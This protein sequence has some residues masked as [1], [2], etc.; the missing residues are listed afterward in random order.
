MVGVVWVWWGFGGAG[1]L[2]LVVSWCSG[3]WVQVWYVGV[4]CQ[5]VRGVGF[6]AV[7]SE[8]WPCLPFRGEKRTHNPWRFQGV[9]QLDS[10]RVGVK[11]GHTT[12]G[13]SRQAVWVFA[14]E[15]VGVKR[16][17]T[18]PTQPLP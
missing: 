3:V 2:G 10:K 15:R 12:P 1:C 14:S 18:T 8:A 16:G 13:G 9:W 11:K 6:G 5:G 4:W 7:G 17:H